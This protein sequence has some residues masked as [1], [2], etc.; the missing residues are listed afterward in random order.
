MKIDIVESSIKKEFI[1]KLNAKL[2]DEEW[3]LQGDMQVTAVGSHGTV[4][5]A[6]MIVNYN[7]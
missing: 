4:F 5:Y 2:E 7:D 6:Q 1:E 3:N